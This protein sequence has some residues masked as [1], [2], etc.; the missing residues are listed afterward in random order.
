M[1]NNRRTTAVVSGSVGL[2]AG[3]TAG[4]LAGRNGFFA[5]TPEAGESGVITPGGALSAD[6]Q[7]SAA[8]GG[9]ASAPNT[10]SA[11][12]IPPMT[13]EGITSWAKQNPYLAI[14]V[15]AAAVFILYKLTR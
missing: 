14:G 10:S 3:A 15:A 4:Y 2:L 12:Q 9:P 11:I 7:V 1:A 13:K 8:A 6:A 5:S